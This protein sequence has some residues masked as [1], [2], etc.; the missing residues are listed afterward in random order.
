ME[1]CQAI[2]ICVK[3]SM[4][5]LNTLATA[6]GVIRESNN[7]PDEFLATRRDVRWGYELWMGRILTKR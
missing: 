5:L 3:G 6:V 7:R 2:S 4:T 1:S